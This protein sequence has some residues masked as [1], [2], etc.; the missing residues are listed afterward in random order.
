M[1]ILVIVAK[2]QVRNLKAEV[3]TVFAW[4]VFERELVGPKLIPNGVNYEIYFLLYISKAKGKQVN[5]PVL[6]PY[7]VWYFGI[8]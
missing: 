6:K 7:G 5:I 4:T 8:V 1:Q 3:K 2:I